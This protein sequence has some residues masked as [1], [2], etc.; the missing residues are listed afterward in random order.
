[1]APAASASFEMSTA[2]ICGER[3]RGGSAP[4][5]PP[6]YKSTPPHPASRIAQC[7]PAYFFTVSSRASRSVL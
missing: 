2:A 5:K 6:R 1:L 7:A 4:Q 3:G